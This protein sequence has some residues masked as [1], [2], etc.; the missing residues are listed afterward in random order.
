MSRAALDV[1]GERRRTLR[2]NISTGSDYDS[3]ISLRHS[4]GSHNTS[5]ASM[6]L[7]QYLFVVAPRL[8]K[9]RSSS[10]F[11]SNPPNLATRLTDLSSAATHQ[12]SFNPEMSCKIDLSLLIVV[13]I[14]TPTVANS[15]SNNS[16]FGGVS[17]TSMQRMVPF[18]L[19]LA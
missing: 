6:I 7:D 11:E 13:I 1:V 5:L 9:L 12:K 2:G 17:S 14:A 3:D 19:I 10:S 4:L 18:K 16:P 8:T 15:M